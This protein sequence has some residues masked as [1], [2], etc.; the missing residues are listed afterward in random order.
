MKKNLE[1]HLF[2]GGRKYWATL[3]NVFLIFQENRQGCRLAPG[4]IWN[5]MISKLLKWFLIQKLK[6][7]LHAELCAFYVPLMNG[8]EKLY[9]MH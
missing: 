9:G 7:I 3:I 8:K 6:I 2:R 4:C 5:R 1:L